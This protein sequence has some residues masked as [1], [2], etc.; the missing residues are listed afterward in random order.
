V[1]LDRDD[2]FDRR[3]AETEAFLKAYK[4]VVLRDLRPGGYLWGP[5]VDTRT[6]PTPARSRT[7]QF[8]YTRYDDHF[9]E[10]MVYYHIDTVQ[11]Y[12]QALG[13]TGTKAI[14][15]RAIKANAHGGSED[16]SYYD[17]SP[18]K[19]DLTFGDGGVDDAE[20][21]EIIIHEY[22]H[23][24]QDAIIPGFG[25]NHEGSAMGEGFGDY[26]AAS[27]FCALKKAKRRP[28]FAEWDVKA[29]VGESEECLRRLDSIK[30]YPEDMV[31]EEHDDGE[32]WS[33]CL[34]MVRK[35]LGRKKADTVILESHSYL[36]PYADFRDGAE[37][38]ILADQNLYGGRR[39]KALTK[40]F[41]RRGIL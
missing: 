14:L 33:A 13:F 6:T 4:K 24:I 17:P 23:A 10:V 31:G 36:S 21:G 25:Q 30:H 12:I 29:V 39:K 20:D 16:N 15:D 5:Y 3:D 27:F 41:Q 32:I 2:L 28:R 19:Q 38:I 26:W 22:G 18:D 7:G 1:T 35:L 9:E 11:R 40:I 34:W 37:S 8:I